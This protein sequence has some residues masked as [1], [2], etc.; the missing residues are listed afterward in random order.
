VLFPPPR[1]APSSSK[2]PETGGD[3]VFIA[4]GT[5]NLIGLTS[6]VITGSTAAGLNASLGLLTVGSGNF[7]RYDGLTAPANLPFGTGSGFVVSSSNS[8]GPLSIKGGQLLLPSGYIS[9]SYLSA[10]NTFNVQ[11]FASFSGGTL[12]PGSYVWTW[13]AGANADSLSLNIGSV[14]EPSSGIL[15]G[16]GIIGLIVQRRRLSTV[17]S[18]NNSEVGDGD[19]DFP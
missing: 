6:S 9:G 15:V 17:A 8:G 10:S 14:P 18:S 3:V 13:G 2:L 19:A 4:N 1:P 12:I 7:Q 5:A 11:T 16:L